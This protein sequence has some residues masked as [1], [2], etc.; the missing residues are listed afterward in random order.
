[1]YVTNSCKLSVPLGPNCCSG[2]SLEKMSVNSNF[3]MLVVEV[4]N[5]DRLLGLREVSR[6]KLLPTQTAEPPDFKLA[7]TSK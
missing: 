2:R 5:W 4:D 1:M 3:G 6:F 7:I